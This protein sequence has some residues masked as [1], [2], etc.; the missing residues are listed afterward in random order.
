MNLIASG[1]AKDVADGCTLAVR[2][3][4]GARK[5]SV[6]GV[7]AD[8]VKIA[9]TAPPV[10]GKANEALIAFLADTLRLPRARI[11]LVSGLTSRA[12]MLRITGKSAAEVAAALLPIEI[13]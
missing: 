3:H 2:V 5:N 12:K 10:D 13:C 4:P 9:L 7:H 11:V 8:A 1:F 6:T